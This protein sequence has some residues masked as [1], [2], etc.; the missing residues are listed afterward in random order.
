MP[1]QSDTT[2]TSPS[3]SLPHGVEGGGKLLPC[4]FCGSANVHLQK[5]YWH[6]VMCFNCGAEG[7]PAK[8]VEVDERVLDS[9][10][11][12]KAIEA[13]NTRYIP[14]GGDDGTV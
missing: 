6:S 10:L 9:A 4:Q 3:A 12:A 2:A 14:T 5:T 11:E 8:G 1:D 7:P 13:W